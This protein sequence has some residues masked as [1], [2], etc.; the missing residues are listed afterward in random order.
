VALLN[1]LPCVGG[2]SLRARFVQ[3]RIVDRLGYDQNAPYPECFMCSDF[4]FAQLNLSKLDYPF[5]RES[6]G[7]AQ[8][9]DHR[10]EL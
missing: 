7:H 10:T 1:F 2:I 5:W 6:L 9:L 8:S 4:W 3:N